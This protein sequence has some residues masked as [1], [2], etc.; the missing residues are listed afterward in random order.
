MC[1]MPAR[2]HDENLKTSCDPRNLECSKAIVGAIEQ[3]EGVDDM[4]CMYVYSPHCGSSVNKI[5]RSFTL[6][7]WQLRSFMWW[8]MDCP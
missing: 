3:C 4:M 6:R 8:P 7:Q 2:C 5:G 1:S